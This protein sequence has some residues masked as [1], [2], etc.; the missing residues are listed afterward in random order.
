MK[1]GIIGFLK[2][3]KIFPA[4]EGKKNPQRIYHTSRSCLSSLMAHDYSRVFNTRKY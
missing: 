2:I 4:I 1:H 3:L